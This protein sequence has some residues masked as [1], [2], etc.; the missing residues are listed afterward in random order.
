MRCLNGRKSIVA[1]LLAALAGIAGLTGG[2]CAQPRTDLLQRAARLAPDLV[3]PNEASNPDTPQMALLKPDGPGPFPALVLLHQCGGLRPV[4]A[5]RL[6][7]S[8]LGWAKEA[9]SRGYVALLLDSLG[10]RAVDSVCFGAKN[11]VNLQ[12]GVRDAL[13]GLA[14][15]QKLPYVDAKNVYFA[16]FSWGAM[17]GLLSSSASWS[18]ALGE[19]RHFRSVAVLY[20]G[21]FDIHPANGQIGRAHV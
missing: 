1:L 21:C 3:L 18:E 6:N 16:G 14:H 15:L 11:G 17:I 12:R 7:W 10:P 19:G 4:N 20:P 9:V 5:V 8:M 2:A 13:Q